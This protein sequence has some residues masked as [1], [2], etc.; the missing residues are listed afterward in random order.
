[1]SR[2]LVFHFS[3]KS[4]KQMLKQKYKYFD[5]NNKIGMRQFRKF[6]KESPYYDVPTSFEKTLC[7]NYKRLRLL[8]FVFVFE[9]NEIFTST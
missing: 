8:S 6:K 3:S 4:V 5:K 1:M 9:V 2:I 7:Y